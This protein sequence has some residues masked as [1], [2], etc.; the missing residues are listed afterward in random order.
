MEVETEVVQENSINQEVNSEVVIDHS[1]EEAEVVLREEVIDLS[2][3]DH[4]EAEVDSE[5]MIMNRDHHSE[6]NKILMIDHQEMREEEA[7]EEVSAEVEI[8][9]TPIDLITTTVD[10]EEEIDHKEEVQDN[11]TECSSIS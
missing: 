2:V 3:K 8:T 1:E 11:T 6:I 5:E 10:S 7:V 9:S 4:T